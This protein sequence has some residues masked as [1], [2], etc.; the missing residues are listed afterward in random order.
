MISPEQLPK[1]PAGYT[2]GYRYKVI[3]PSTFDYLTL[4]DEMGVEVSSGAIVSLENLSAWQ[5]AANI[6]M[7]EIRTPATRKELTNRFNG[8]PTKGAN[9]SPEEQPKPAPK[10]KWYSWLLK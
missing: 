5:V 6:C 4:I 1:P 2:W 7:T 9:P 3:G 10:P 8:S